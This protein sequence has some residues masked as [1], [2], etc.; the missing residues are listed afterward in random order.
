MVQVIIFVFAG[1][2]YSNDMRNA[3][4]TDYRH[5]TH[6]NVEVKWLSFNTFIEQAYSLMA[7][8]HKQKNKKLIMPYDSQNINKCIP[9]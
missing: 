6:L 9:Y 2:L 4:F 7:I 3:M 8:V 1:Y 5:I